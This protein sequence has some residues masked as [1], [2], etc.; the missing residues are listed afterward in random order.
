VVLELT[1]EGHTR[2]QTYGQRDQF[3]PELIYFSDCIIHNREPEPS[4][5]EGLIDVH[6]I[7]SL[8]HSMRSGLPVMLKQLQRQKRPSL[9]QAIYRPRVRNANLVHVTAPT[10]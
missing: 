1:R 10:K 8:Y 6:I 3:A 5:L 9:R 4:G 7:R 2:R